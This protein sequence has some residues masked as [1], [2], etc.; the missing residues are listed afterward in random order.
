SAACWNRERPGEPSLTPML[1][2]ASTRIV[3][4]GLPA[5]GA[6]RSIHTGL[7]NTT[8]APASPSP[9]NPRAPNHVR[10]STELG[11]PRAYQTTRA[12]PTTAS[13]SQTAG[14]ISGSNRS[15]D[16]MIETP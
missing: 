6:A 9:H 8:N 16:V 15:V 3:S 4:D 1:D 14:E 10:F 7:S 13:S 11:R 12:I 2:D 5:G